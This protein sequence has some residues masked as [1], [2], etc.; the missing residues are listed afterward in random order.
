MP[1]RLIEN[2][3]KFLQSFFNNFWLNFQTFLK[4]Y[5]WFLLVCIGFKVLYN[6]MEA[7]CFGDTIK[8][9]TTD[10]L[11]HQPDRIYRQIPSNTKI[12]NI[13]ACYGSNFFRAQVKVFTDTFDIKHAHIINCAKTE[14]CNGRDLY[15]F[16]VPSEDLCKSFKILLHKRIAQLIWSESVIKDCYPDT[17]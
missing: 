2:V 5:A 13:F 15:A 4:Y 12:V 6:I 11:L 9:F 8:Q 17:V 1:F 14:E 10:T 3:W 7:T 16:L